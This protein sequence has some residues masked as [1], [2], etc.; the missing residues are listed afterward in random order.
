MNQ[1]VPTLPSAS[2]STARGVS[3]RCFLK[4]AAVAGVAAPFALSSAGRAASPNAKLN[5]AS[6]GVGGMG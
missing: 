6:I 2:D 1:C 3:R 5:H 4:A